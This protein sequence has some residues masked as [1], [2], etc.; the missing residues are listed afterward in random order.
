MDKELLKV[1]AAHLA[2]IVAYDIAPLLFQRPACG[3]GEQ[4]RMVQSLGTLHLCGRPERSSRLL[5]SSAHHFGSKPA[6]GRYFTQSPSL[7]KSDFPIKIND[8]K[9]EKKEKDQDTGEAERGKKERK[10][11]NNREKEPYTLRERSG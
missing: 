3:L 9:E 10:S 11:R 8:R 4:K 6:G 5:I 7:Y 1:T 2:T